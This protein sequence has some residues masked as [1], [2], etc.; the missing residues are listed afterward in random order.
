MSSEPNLS[1]EDRVT[2]SRVDLL[3]SIVRRM[4]GR[5]WRIVPHPG[6]IG[7]EQRTGGKSGALR[8]AIFGVNDGL[9]S[10][11]SLIFGVAGAGVDNQ[12]V[13][14]AGVAGLLA[15]AFSMAAGE[16]ISVRVQ[17][18][19]FERLIHLEAHEIG[20]EPEAERA[21]LA[22]IYVRKGLPRDLADRLATELMKDPAVALDTHAREE[23]GLDPDEGLG[24]PIAVAGS[25][26]A[27]FSAGA[28]VP[29]VPFL[30][31]SGAGAVA[32]SAALSGGALFGVGAAMSYLTGRN[33]IL[34]GLACSRSGRP[35]RGSHIWWA[36]SLM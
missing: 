27:T 28:F 35:P 1:S 22:N 21:E 13:V 29:L 11:L 10:N 7:G 30:F 18:E 33:P 16:Y 14:L 2:K 8:A 12:V 20:S 36:R 31:G 32:V 5:Q 24:S 3:S 4:R 26:F 25:S 34:S 6:P 9:V 23:L 15:G 19:V 17:R